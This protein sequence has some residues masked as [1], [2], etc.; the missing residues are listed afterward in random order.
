MSSDMELKEL[1]REVKCE[2]A[3][4]VNMCDMYHC[5]PFCV[6]EFLHTLAFVSASDNENY[7][8]GLFLEEGLIFLSKHT[9]YLVVIFVMSKFEFWRQL[10]NHFSFSFAFCN[11][12]LKLIKVCP[13]QLPLNF[14]LLIAFHEAELMINIFNR[15][16]TLMNYVCQVIFNC[17]TI[18]SGD[19]IVAKEILLSEKRLLI[20]LFITIYMWD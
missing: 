19:E 16:Y 6:F 10:L 20:L 17:Y 5:I 12:I 11:P 4:F 13:Q 7:I 14:I 3:F 8:C 9:F 15:N 1:I 2:I 18:P